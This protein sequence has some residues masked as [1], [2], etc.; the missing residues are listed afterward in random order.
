MRASLRAIAVLLFTVPSAELAAQA[1]PPTFGC[2]EPTHRQFDFWLGDW[3]V[4]VGGQPAGTNQITLVEQGCV[5]HERWSG[6]RGGTGQSFNWY[7]R[8]DRLWHQVWVDN[9]G[10]SLMLSG[11]FQDGR[12]TLTGTAPGPNGAPQSQRLSFF[13]NPDGT[14]RQLWETSADGGQTWQSTFDG[15]YRRKR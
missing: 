5:L 13:K 4:T 11:T 12:L 8:A 14:V 10:N 6:S 2:P 15:L 7:D 9:Q 1:G 3:D